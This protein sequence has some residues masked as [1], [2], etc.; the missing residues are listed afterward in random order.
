MLSFG[1]FPLVTKVGIRWP[2]VTLFQSLVLL[3]SVSISK[4]INFLKLVIPLP[5]RHDHVH[6]SWKWNS[7]INS[8]V[9]SL[10]T[11]RQKLFI[12]VE[13]PQREKS[14]SSSLR[15]LPMLM[16]L[17]GIYFFPYYLYDFCESLTH[18]IKLPINLCKS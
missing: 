5:C 7:L 4:K 18:S 15:T 1:F 6:R 2:W 9:I 8:R 17:L 13:E 3:E 16:Q 11:Q 12:W 14:R 10:L